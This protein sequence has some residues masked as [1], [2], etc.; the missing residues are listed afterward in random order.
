MTEDASGLGKLGA[1]G[2]LREV[3][4]RDDGEFADF[5]EWC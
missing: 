4:Q 2:R 5:A 3:D 1:K